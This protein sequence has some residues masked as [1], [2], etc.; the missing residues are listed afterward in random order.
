VYET[1]ET[2]ETVERIR[3]A[4]GIEIDDPSEQLQ[5]ELTAEDPDRQQGE[6]VSGILGIREPT[7]RTSRESEM[8]REERL[9]PLDKGDRIR[10]V[11]VKYDILDAS[12]IRLWKKKIEGLLKLQKCWK[13]VENTRK[14]RLEGKTELLHRAM[15]DEDYIDHD[16]LAVTY[17]TAYISEGDA[18][19][20]KNLEISGDIWI[21]LMEKYEAVNPRRKV[22]LLMQLFTWKMDPKMKISEAIQDLER[23]HEEVKDVWEKEYLGQD[24]L[25]VLFLCG[26]PPE[27]EAYADGLR[28]IG[29]TKRAVILS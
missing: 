22:N 27:Y 15:Q 12:N 9:P 18:T 5:A 6:P 13:V 16:L 19:A 20:V 24:A 29:E 23:L 8:S 14:M 26:L 11:G 17:L 28:S 21:Y 2:D 25:M 10:P 7:Y 1:A 3:S 4:S